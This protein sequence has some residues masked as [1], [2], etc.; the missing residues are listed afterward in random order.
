MSD[1]ASDT[2]AGLIKKLG[3]L[4]K[5]QPWQLTPH[6]WTDPLKDPNWAKV[7][8]LIVTALD[9][10]REDGAGHPLADLQ[11]IAFEESMKPDAPPHVHTAALWLTD[12]RLR[13]EAFRADPNDRDIRRSLEDR[14]ILKPKREK[15]EAKEEPRKPPP[16]P[17]PVEAAPEP[18]DDDLETQLSL[19]GDS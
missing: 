2:Y 3:K 12:T 4:R 11:E 16:P 19:L 6:S 10:M 17:T 13:V 5:K 7:S 14:G 18:V 8:P 1:L 15:V 9:E